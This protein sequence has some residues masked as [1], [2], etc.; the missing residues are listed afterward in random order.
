VAHSTA[1][2]KAN[3]R[4]ELASFSPEMIAEDASAREM[5]LEM[6][7]LTPQVIETFLTLFTPL[8]ACNFSPYYLSFTDGC[9]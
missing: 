5:L 3:T 1:F 8:Y 4:A 9:R 2:T 6:P 7:P